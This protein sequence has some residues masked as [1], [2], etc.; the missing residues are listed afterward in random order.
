MPK[1]YK[2]FP[3]N[4]HDEYN[5]PLEPALPLRAFLS[6]VRTFAEPCCSNGQLVEHVESFGPLCIH[7]D[8]IR[9][10]TDALTD[11]VLRALIVDAI[12][13]NPP[14][15]WSILKQMLGLFP[16]IAPTWMLLE[17]DFKYLEHAMPYMPMCSDV[18]P[19][20][21]IR[22]FADTK[23]KS[24]KRYA[25]YRFDV[26]NTQLTIFHPRQKFPKALVA[27]AAVAKAA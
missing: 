9:Y 25:W 4:K 10:G 19:I 14:Y 18:V 27:P 8:D 7:S 5:T 16:T 12:I 13:T 3:R 2:K 17:A 11:P 15:T 21:Q 1:Q 24:F 6:G 23:H 20:G 22:W 26:R